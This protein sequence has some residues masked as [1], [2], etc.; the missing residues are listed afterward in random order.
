MCL[1]WLAFAMIPALV[2]EPTRS[3]SAGNRRTPGIPPAVSQTQAAPQKIKLQFKDSEVY[4][5]ARDVELK[6]VTLRRVM[7][8]FPKERIEYA[9]VEIWM[10]NTEIDACAQPELGDVASLPFKSPED[11]VLVWQAANVA[12]PRTSYAETPLGKAV[13]AGE[14]PDRFGK[15]VVLMWG[16]GWR[17]ALTD[18][19]KEAP[20]A[21]EFPFWDKGPSE[22]IYARRGFRDFKEG[23]EQE[24]GFTLMQVIGQTIGSGPTA[25]PWIFYHPGATRPRHKDLDFYGVLRKSDNGGHQLTFLGFQRR[26]LWANGDVTVTR[27]C[28]EIIHEKRFWSDGKVYP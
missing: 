10:S 9:K 3:S 13:F 28:P 20:V 22:W 2:P 18:L 26:A 27:V 25:T 6:T 8:S 24:F 15:P 17:Q 14:W 7:K 16:H 1:T 11:F 4:R 21:L 5:E 12:K 19:Y 23:R